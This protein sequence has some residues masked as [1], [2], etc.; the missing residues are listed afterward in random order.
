MVHQEYDSP[1]HVTQCYDQPTLSLT[2]PCPT[3]IE[4]AARF[5]IDGFG[6]CRPFGELVFLPAG[7]TLDAHGAGGLQRFF[8]CRFDPNMFR[9]VTHITDW[10][11][12]RLRRCLDIRGGEMRGMV[13]R[14]MKELHEPGFG[15]PLFVDAAA[16]LI[17]IQL[18]R[19]LGMEPTG[20]RPPA[21][22]ADWQLRRIRQCLYETEYEWPSTAKLAG[23]CGVSRSHLSRSFTQ[24]T[25]LTLF[26]YAKNIRME[27]AVSLLARRECSV[28]FVAVFLGFS[29][30][31]T[32]S[33]A[34]RRETG[35]AP[36]MFRRANPDLG[37]P[38]S[39]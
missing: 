5:D 6:A 35:M 16:T 31:G 33:T 39:I 36:S 21:S 25:G 32:F 8:V 30:V 14:V 29:S 7:L 15:A 3:G 26:E 4:G 10:D 18:A 28:G 1:A 20:C 11:A 19:H 24:S 9:E 2:L 13:R 27:R 23:L 17:L 37:R 38:T 12:V 34:F 22:L